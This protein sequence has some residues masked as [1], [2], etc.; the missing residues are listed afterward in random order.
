MTVRDIAVI[1][2]ET[3]VHIVEVREGV[4]GKRGVQGLPGRPGADGPPG[5]PGKPINIIL[6]SASTINV[7]AENHADFYVS[8]NNIDDAVNLILGATTV[9]A[10]NIE[11][12]ALGAVC[13]FNQVSSKRII[14]SSIDPS[15]N[16]VVPLGKI[17]ATY[18]TGSTVGALVTGN[19]TW[20]L[21]G[22]LADVSLEI[23]E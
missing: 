14:I 7:T 13:F 19:D 6:T 3:P 1:V 9:I 17:A 2:Q 23:I 21:F 8:N 5:P 4:Q 15:I 12:H 18:G 20:T 10:N 22:D 16:I 11:Q